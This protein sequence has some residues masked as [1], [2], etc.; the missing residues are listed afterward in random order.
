MLLFIRLEA[1]RKKDSFSV[2]LLRM[3]AAPI[4]LAITV[5]V[6]IVT[7]TFLTSLTI[8]A[9]I[10]IIVT[11]AT[12]FM[13]AIT[14][15]AVT[16]VTITTVAVAF[17]AIIATTTVLILVVHRRFFP[18]VK[19][20][21][22]LLLRS[23]EVFS[24]TRRSSPA[25]RESS[26]LHTCHFDVFDIFSIFVIVSNLRLV[27]LFRKDNMAFDGAINGLLVI[28]ED[29][30]DSLA[31]PLRLDNRGDVQLLGGVAASLRKNAVNTTLG[32]AT[33]ITAVQNL[34]IFTDDIVVETLFSVVSQDCQRRLASTAASCWLHF[35]PFTTIHD[36]SL[37][38]HVELGG[39]V[40]FKLLVDEAANHEAENVV[41]H[42]GKATEHRDME[43]NRVKSS[44]LGLGE[45]RVLHNRDSCNGVI[46]LKNARVVLVKRI[47]VKVFFLE[48]GEGPEKVLALL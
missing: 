31:L 24:V 8:A 2:T 45:R 37:C 47:E 38:G 40:V 20:V 41:E 16:T 3:S 46:A 15:I 5:A 1:S 4:L 7:R 18:V 22:T 30:V 34:L 9:F 17:L 19:F 23:N 39:E 33:D 35:S 36:Y 21:T 29:V 27:L 48:A 10:P 26:R 12:L 28:L 13:F 25:L 32:H 6:T 14:T 43:P 11:T 42:D 44:E